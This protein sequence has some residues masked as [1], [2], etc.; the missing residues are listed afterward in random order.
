MADSGPTGWVQIREFS[1]SRSSTGLA[2]PMGRQSYEVHTEGEGVRR[3][4][5]DTGFG[6]IRRH[7]AARAAKLGKH[8][9]E[10]RGEGSR[11]QGKL[12]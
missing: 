10:G 6:R 12:E 4:V 5:L 7:D 1:N 8:A 3:P 9:S 2:R 11:E